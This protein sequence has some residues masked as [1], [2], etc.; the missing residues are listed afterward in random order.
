[1]HKI[2]KPASEFYDDVSE[3]YDQMTQFSQRLVKEKSVLKAW[4]ERY[5][6]GKTLDLGCGSG[7]H[8]ILLNRLGV[9]AIGADISDEMINKAREN[10][11]HAEEE[12]KFI[13][14]GFLDIQRNLNSIFDTVLIL[15]NSLPHLT[16]LSDLRSAILQFHKIL[17]KKG[18]LIFQILNYD[19]ILQKKNRI[20]SIN[21]SGE[22]EFIRFYD[23]FEELIRFNILHLTWKDNTCEHQISSTDLYPFTRG[24]L[25]GILE[26]NGFMIKDEF[27]SM[28]FKP[29]NPDKSNNL[30]M[31]CQNN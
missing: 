31:V 5:Q 26:D 18:R 25:V 17:N 30:V 22:Q 23:F 6:F 3:F 4:V 21:K 1:M 20:V 16:S 8:T 28:D 19:K 10:A 14:T 7:L 29:Y 11:Q 15:G 2:S 27:G 24:E 12:I 13:K 9:S